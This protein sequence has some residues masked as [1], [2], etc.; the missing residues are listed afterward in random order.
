[1]DEGEGWKW[2]YGGFIVDRE[3]RG[4][5]GCTLEASTVQGWIERYQYGRSVEVG[6]MAAGIEWVRPKC[7]LSYRT[8]FMRLRGRRL[9]MTC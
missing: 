5:S 9:F 2:R 6:C 7:I 1:M 8:E 3:S 4:S